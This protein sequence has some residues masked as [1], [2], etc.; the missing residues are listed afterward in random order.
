MLN[1]LFKTQGKLQIQSGSIFQLSIG[2]LFSVQIMKIGTE[3]VLFLTKDH[4]VPIRSY[5]LTQSVT[6][7]TPSPGGK[8]TQA[9]W[10]PGFSM[11]IQTNI[12]KFSEKLTMKMLRVYSSARQKSTSLTRQACVKIQRKFIKI[13]QKRERLSFIQNKCQK[14]NQT[15]PK[16]T[17]FDPVRLLAGTSKFNEGSLA[18]MR[19]L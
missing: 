2:S 5:R 7:K 4:F 13:E 19:L 12:K 10:S 6:Y 11:P 17:I 15:A 9:S 3:A 8:L 1:N 18:R 14:I 16:I